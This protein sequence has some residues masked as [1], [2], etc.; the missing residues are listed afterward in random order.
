MN[1][2]YQNSEDFL[3][4]ALKSIPL[5]SQTFS[6]SITSFPV[7]AA[8]LFLEKGKGSKV[9][10]IDG[11]EYIDFVS[12]LACVNLGYC[13]PDVDKAVKEQLE[14]GVTFSLPHRLE[15]EVAEKIIEMVPCAE[16]VRFG[17]NGT[18]ATSAAIRLA[19]AYTKREHIAVCGYHGWQDWYIGST[20]RDMGVPKATKDLT[21]KFGFND[22]DSLEAI[23]SQNEIAGIILEPMN[24]N[25][26][27][28]D[29]LKKVKELATKYNAVLI[30]DETVT[31]FRYAPGGA[32]EYFDVTPDL[33]TFGKGLANGYPV[34]AITGKK[35]IMKL[36][37]DIFFSGTFGGETLSLAA[38][39]ATLEKINREGVTEKVIA[40]GNY[41][42]EKFLE[43]TQELGLSEYFTIKGHPTWQFIQFQ[44]LGEVDNFHIKTLYLQELFKRGILILSTFNFS[45]AHSKE[46]VDT[47]LTAYREVLPILKN[48][49]DRGEVKSVLNCQPLKP[50]FQVR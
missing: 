37:E 23:L 8:P 6:K 1:S 11:N 34:S 26:P 19:R 32:Q 3:N 25:F 50:L 48:A 49:I 22:I 29:F 15:T 41:F 40:T 20:T 43:L 16:M 47:L 38:A 14:N 13:D 46:D 39:K 12:A 21:H 28:D 18:D 4:R 36:M 5:A 7:G 17:K 35:E 2:K 9:W 42:K 31:G 33:A 45:Y 24:I 27:E 10:D 30:F 44:N